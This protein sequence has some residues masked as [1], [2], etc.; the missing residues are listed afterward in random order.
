MTRQ[1]LFLLS[2]LVVSQVTLAQRFDV[3]TVSMTGP[4]DDR[5]NVVFLPDGY[6]EHELD[7]F[8]DD[9]DWMMNALFAK[10]PYPSYRTYFNCFAIKVPSAESGAANDPDSLINNYF[11]S[12]FNTAGIWR[13]VVPHRSSRVQSVLRDNFPQYDQ[14]VVIVNESRYGGS[15]GWMATSTTHSN[16]PEI[17]IHEIGHSFAGLSDEYWAGANYARENIN[18]TQETDPDK[19][20]W[21]RWM[22][23]RSTGIY[24]H[25]ESPDWKRPHQNCEMRY[26]NR[27]FCPVCQEAI[28]STILDLSNPIKSYSPA[29]GDF[30]FAGSS[31]LFSVSLLEPQPNTLSIRWTLNSD[32]IA[33]NIDSIYVDANRL[34]PG[35][36]KVVAFILDTTQYIRKSS[37]SR[38]HLNKV[39]WDFQYTS[40]GLSPSIRH[41]KLNVSLYPNPAADQV[42]IEFSLE[43]SSR[44]SIYLIDQKGQL[45]SI[46]KEQ[47]WH[48]GHHQFNLDLTAYGLAAGLYQVIIQSAHGPIQLPLVI[49]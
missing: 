46:K 35:D 41:E 32:S 38:V 2:F 47:D 18:M 28:A 5:I 36:N 29:E 31:M 20:R 23:F 10:D 17:C 45:I 34:V 16:G 19:V 49:R 48:A 13:L 15:G 1:I 33:G 22:N 30:T 3:D 40:T 39:I 26:L 9:V 11:G 21:S 7:K 6:Q 25:S 12:S 8:L 37:H 44:L 27:E 24:S 42:S 14:V 43:Q 4:V